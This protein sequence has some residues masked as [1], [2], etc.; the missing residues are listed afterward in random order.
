MTDPTIVFETTRPRRSLSLKRRPWMFAVALL[1]ISHLGLTQRDTAWGQT[2][3]VRMSVELETTPEELAADVQRTQ[4]AA[5]LEPAIRQRLLDLY[6]QAQGELQSATEWSRKASM[7][8]AARQSAP[9]EL[10]EMQAELARPPVVPTISQKDSDTLAELESLLAK[11][12]TELKAA[13]K[14]LAGW[15]SEPQRRTDWRRIE[16]P[17]LTEAANQVLEDLRKQ[18]EGSQIPTQAADRFADARR[19][20]SWATKQRV[21]SELAALES[22][23]L[24][25]ESG[26]DWVA[27]KHDLAARRV[28]FMEGQVRRWQQSVDQRRQADADSQERDA[29]WAAAMA[30]PQL[31]ALAEQN[32]ELTKRQKGSDGWPAAI[33]DASHQVTAMAEQRSDLQAR[34][35]RVREKVK[36]AGHTNAIGQLLKREQAELPDIHLNRE[37]IQERQEKVSEVQLQL[38]ELE[39]ARA[40]VQEVLRWL[41]SD[42]GSDEPRH[43]D[44]EMQE[45]LQA[46]E[47]QRTPMDRENLKRQLH[48]LLQARLTI[49]GSLIE[50]ANT[51]FYKLLD[52]DEN[53]Q[54]LITAANE[55]S[56]YLSERVLWVKSD[57]ALGSADLLRAGEAV[58]WL[59]EPAKWIGLARDLRSDM[60]HNPLLYVV[61]ACLCTLIIITRRFLRRRIAEIGRKNCASAPVG[62]RQTFDA[63]VCTL[64]ITAMSPALCWFVAW[65]LAS[66]W[67]ASEF[68]K[69][70]AFGLQN[71]AIVLGTTAMLR[72]VCRR[73][74]LAE[75]HFQW[76]PSSLAV[77]RRNLRWLV[78]IGIP[79]TFLVAVIEGLGRFQGREL[80]RSSLGRLAFMMGMVILAFFF[81]RTLHPKRG[82]PQEIIARNPKGWLDRFKLIWYPL[83]VATPLLSAVLAASGYYYTALQLTWRLQATVWVGLAV[84]IGYSFL[85]RCVLVSRRNMAIQQSRRR[86]TAALSQ[87]SELVAPA[88]SHEGTEVAGSCVETETE[89]DLTAVHTQ[90]NRLVR[91]C[92]VL[93]MLIGVW[94]VW[95]DVL[96]AL[97]VVAHWELWT[98]ASSESTT[99]TTDKDGKPSTETVIRTDAI[100]I[101]DLALAMLVVLMTLAASRNLP[102]LLEITVLQRLP[103]DA[104]GRYAIT[105][106]SRYVITVFGLILA[107]R[108]I[109]IGWSNVQWL[110]AAITV[111]LGFGLQEIFA[112]FVSGLIILF[113]RPMRVGDTVT[114]GGYT[115]TVSRIR[116]R[117]TTIT[118]GDRKELIVP[119]REFITGQLIN[120]TLS[121]TVLR[122]SIKIGI[123]YGSDTKLATQLLLDAAH[124]HPLVLQHPAPSAIFQNFGN[125]TLDLELGVFI[126][127]IEHFSAVRHELNMTIDSAFKEHGIEMAFPQHD[128]HVRSITADFPGLEILSAKGVK[129]SKKAA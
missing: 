14:E 25:Y 17:K 109:G 27:A 53:Q 73:H 72:Q 102:G 44:P 96:P 112:N 84:V 16:L 42:G 41:D 97:R 23:R 80:Y 105:A 106:I 61:A 69:T 64:L 116:I 98:I 28:T 68:A 66:T 30:H 21:Q 9:Q 20:L 81:Q 6:E 18:L 31:R 118:D 78:I 76:Y 45:A 91:S 43:V 103:L 121:D 5:E 26:I 94:L 117:A 56:E 119:N 52:L 63:V 123:A 100:T 77:L 93:A 122:M 75:A 36:A 127:G 15:E 19:K 8:E 88:V 7:S 11:A 115:G 65:R 114:V 90:T 128:V 46:V 37:E 33:A 85:L 79:L 67:A 47:S 12:D 108:A 83:I 89:V 107:F 57:P 110:V 50:D 87:S 22:E 40:S 62:L 58:R 99:S 2:P 38:I 95:V 70:V 10:Q 120:W 54:R 49:V 111:G 129:T 113:E 48:D 60:F 124:A 71:I 39:D 1:L 13:R 126:S 4:T 51:Y 55:Y 59:F 86:R 92:A 24:R 35:A 125:S 74:G 29:R 82:A 104:G 3:A 101:G 34:F 32:A